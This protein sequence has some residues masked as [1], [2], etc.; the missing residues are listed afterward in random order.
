MVEASFAGQ[1]I[2]VTV[3]VRALTRCAVLF[4]FFQMRKYPPKRAINDTRLRLLA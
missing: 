4:A 1:T 2:A 3:C